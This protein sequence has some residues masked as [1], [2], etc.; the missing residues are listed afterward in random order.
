MLSFTPLLRLPYGGIIIFL[1]IG[2]VVPPMVVGPPPGIIRRRFFDTNINS[3]LLP[4]IVWAKIR[5]GRNFLQGQIDDWTCPVEDAI[6]DT[7]F[8]AVFKD[9]DHVM[10]VDTNRDFYTAA[11]RSSRNSKALR[12]I[13][14][15]CSGAAV[16]PHRREGNTVLAVSAGPEQHKE[17]T[18]FKIIL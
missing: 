9:G 8:P 15:Y 7:G 1:P 14:S 6:S 5:D 12:N 17:K 13:E 2:V 11:R 16:S 4:I 10:P 3:P 18:C